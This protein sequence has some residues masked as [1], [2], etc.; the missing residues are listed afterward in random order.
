MITIKGKS[1]T[2]TPF[3]TK[4]SKYLKPCLINPIIVTPINTIAAKTNVTII[5]LVTVNE[6]GNMPTILQNKTNINR[7]N[8]NGKKDLALEP[9]VSFIIFATKV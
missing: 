7:V 9:A 1:T 3:G 2:G 6:Y 5:W 4:S 8:T